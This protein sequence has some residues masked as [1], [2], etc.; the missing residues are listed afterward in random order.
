[1]PI[2]EENT[3]RSKQIMDFVEITLNLVKLEARLPL[4]KLEK[5]QSLL[6][7]FLDR[8]SCKRRELETLVFFFFK[9]YMLRCLIRACVLTQIDFLDHW[10]SRTFSLFEN[11]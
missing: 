8:K 5:C 1:M 3:Y 10:N 9:L 4:E 6:H 11:Y 7:E 2:A